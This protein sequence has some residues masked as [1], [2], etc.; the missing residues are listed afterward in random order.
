MQLYP[1]QE[2]AIAD[3]IGGKHICVMQVGSGKSAVMM[4]WIASKE[5]K[6]VLIITTAS[7]SKSGDF[8]RDA[9]TWNGVGWRDSL[10]AFE[11]ISWHKV[12]EW[13]M[14]HIK[15]LSEWVYGIDELQRAKAGISSG[16]GKA[17][18]KITSHTENWAGFTA[19]PGDNWLHFYPY[20]T[21]CGF[22]KNKTS[23]LHTFAVTQTF[24][25]FPEIVGWINED[26]LKKWW[27][28]ISTTPDTSQM[29]RELPPEVHEVVE[30]KKPKEYDTVKKTRIFNGEFVDT[31]MGICHAL[32]SI[33]FTKEKKQWL[34]DF[35]DG[36]GDGC[37]I[38]YNYINEGNEIEQIIHK[39]NKKAKVWRIDG[40]HHEIP[41]A[42]T[43][44]KYD[45]VLCQ[46]QSGSEALNLQFLHYWVSVTPT[47]SYMTS[48]Q[49]RGRIRRLGQT[50]TQFY[51]Y[52]KCDGIESDV[53][54][55]L[56]QKKDFSEDV[57]V[58]NNMK[59]EN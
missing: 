28:T 22:V 6:K 49:A 18:L 59:G 51:Y 27:D 2:K 7:K 50:H 21:A 41:T 44:G 31:T 8:T 13:V 11:I 33:S 36:L 10:D 9:D 14:A 57:Y 37:V 16:M 43:I 56:H 42:E 32:R 26:V 40:S 23:F 55:A 38:F 29:Y 19:T 20:F 30:F 45:V 4:K 17:F 54:E 35:I 53:Y 24:K 34:S 3:L 12:S 47:Y 15:D 48:V 39:A 46:W 25:G 5:P 58:K 52:L 1:F